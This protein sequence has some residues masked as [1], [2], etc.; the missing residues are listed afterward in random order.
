MALQEQRHP[1][2]CRFQSQRPLERTAT[3]PILNSMDRDNLHALVDSMPEGA[4]ENAK[5]MLEHLQVWPPQPPPE[6]ER[7]RQIRQE[8]MERFRRSIRPGMG[9]GG[10]GTSSFDPTTR[11]GHAGHSHWEDDTLVHQTLHFFKGH[12]IAVT[13]RLRSADGEKAIRYSHEA[14]GPKGGS[15]QQELRFDVQ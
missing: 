13:E 15:V 3:G 6:M 11:Y 1:R 4:L 12:E 2:S 8:H 5:R 10:G 14:Q 7:M 9:G